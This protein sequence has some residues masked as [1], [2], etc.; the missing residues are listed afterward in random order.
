MIKLVIG[1]GNSGANYELNRH[2]IGFMFVDYLATRRGLTF[3]EDKRFYAHI[4]QANI[5]GETVYLLK[6]QTFVN[7]SGK[8]VL[9]VMQFY[10]IKPAETL[11]VHDELDLPIDCVKLKFAGGHAGH[12]GIRDIASKL[13][14]QDFYRLRFG[15]GRP[16][17]EMEIT[18][19]VLQNFS[20]S[21][22]EIV[23]KNL[24]MVTELIT[25]IITD[26]HA[27]IMQKLHTNKE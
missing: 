16:Q 10:K 27:E 14:S 13:S 24:K 17:N 19:F 12:N 3:K 11:V 23:S 26:N 8:A 6:P 9:A 15:I 22:L 2:N 4:C 18:D 20:Q 7:N 21:E 5:V 1:L 25:D